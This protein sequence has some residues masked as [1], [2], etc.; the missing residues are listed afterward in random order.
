[1]PTEVTGILWKSRRCPYPELSLQH[2]C[3]HS[4]KSFVI[5]LCVSVLFL[6]VCLG[7]VCMPGTLAVLVGGQKNISDAPELG[8]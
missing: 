4:L 3:S 6:I 2:I 5:I 8:L 1:M 7:T